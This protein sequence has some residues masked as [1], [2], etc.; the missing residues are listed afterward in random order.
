MKLSLC[1]ATHNEASNIHYPLDSTYNWVDEVIIVDGKS[2]DATVEKAK[3]YGNKVKVY[4]EDNPKMFHINKQKALRQAQGEWILQ[5]DADEAISPELAKEIQ[6]II[7][8]D[9]KEMEEYQQNLPNRELFLRHEKILEKKLQVTSYKLQEYNAFF[10]PRSNY[11]L[12]K[13]L[14]YGGVYPDGAIRLIKKGKAHFPCKDVHEIMK[15]DGKTGWLNNDLLHYDSPTFERY[16]AR[17]NRYIEMIAS[18][19]KKE[20]LEKNIFNFITYVFIKPISWFLMT[21]IRHKGI[22]DGWQGIVFSFFSALRFPK[23]YMKF[24]RQS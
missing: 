9:E 23:A 1:L 7:H 5:L 24:M 14:K 16:I 20:K 22:L 3:S 18:E 17:N 19:Y 4:L 10:L 11:F 15:V 12:G 6:K 8:M 2:T 21:T 13:F